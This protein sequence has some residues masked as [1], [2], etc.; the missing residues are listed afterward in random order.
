[1]KIRIPCVLI[2]VLLLGPAFLAQNQI[3]F[4]YGI[5]EQEETTRPGLDESEIEDVFGKNTDIVLLVPSGDV[6]TE[7]RLVDDV[8]DVKDVSITISYV[9][10]FSIVIPGAVI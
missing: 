3:T 1:I 6:A 2:V 5:G 8:N 7:E 10:A 4:I 9:S